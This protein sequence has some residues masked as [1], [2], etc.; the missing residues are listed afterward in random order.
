VKSI[1]G[2]VTTGDAWHFMELTGN[3]IVV[4]SR[5]FFLSEVDIILWIITTICNPPLT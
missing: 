2:C 5:R 3:T 4:D 1:Y